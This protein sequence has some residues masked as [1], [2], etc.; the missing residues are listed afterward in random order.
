MDCSERQ[1]ST[2]ARADCGI[3]AVEAELDELARLRGEG[4]I[5]LREWMAAREPLQRRL[6]ALR[7]DLRAPVAPPAVLTS[8]GALRAAWDDLSFDQRREVLASVIDRVEVGPA[9]RGRQ[10]FDPNRVTLHY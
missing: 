9:V 3:V 5:S 7:A 6:E 4:A 2:A 1:P 8:P 10:R